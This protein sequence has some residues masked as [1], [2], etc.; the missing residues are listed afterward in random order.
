MVWVYL[1]LFLILL[2]FYLA[3]PK[4]SYRWK[5][6][7]SIYIFFF[8]FKVFFFFNFPDGDTAFSLIYT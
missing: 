7:Q 4:P 6:I 3:G 1:F 2:P 8:L 5:L